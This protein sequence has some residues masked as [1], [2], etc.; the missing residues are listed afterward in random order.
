M[1]TMQSSGRDGP[2]MNQKALWQSIFLA[3][4]KPQ[5]QSLASLAKRDQVLGDVKDL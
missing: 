3:G 2:M 4:R 1:F 5:V